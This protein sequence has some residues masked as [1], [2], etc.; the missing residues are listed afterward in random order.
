M[1]EPQRLSFGLDWSPNSTHVAL[2][3]AQQIKA[4]ER[5]RLS[6]EFVSPDSKNAP[7]T[8]ADGLF[9]GSLQLGLCPCDQL[10]TRGLRD[11]LLAVAALIRK[12]ISAVVCNANRGIERPRDLANKT[13]SSCGYPLEARTLN[14]LIAADGGSG[15]VIEVCP[16]MRMD[17]DTQLHGSG[18]ADCAWQYVTWE[19]LRASRAGKT[20]SLFK[21]R[22][23]GV[24]FGYMNCIAT[25][26]ALCRDQPNIVVDFLDAVREGAEF[27]ARDPA[28][29]AQ[30]LYE[31]SGFHP[32]LADLELVAASIVMLRDMGAL[33]NLEE[34]SSASSDMGAHCDVEVSSSSSASTL[35]GFGVMESAVWRDFGELIIKANLIEDQQQRAAALLACADEPRGVWTNRY[36][37]ALIADGK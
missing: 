7:K 3:V 12:D 30:M 20:F 15:A 33:G 22:D 8:P 14:A 13:Y 21:L 19:V 26:T 10:V 32:E 1:A 9:D 34:V 16:H 35:R 4:F 5:R 31:G 28:A 25:T 23:Y 24:N 27:A 29:A 11:G 17:S 36:L 2:F 18:E 37:E 6:V